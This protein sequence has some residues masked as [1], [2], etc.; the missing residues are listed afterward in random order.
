M[1]KTNLIISGVV[2]STTAFMFQNCSN[3]KY[4]YVSLEESSVLKN[5]VFDAQQLVGNIEANGGAIPSENLRVR[6]LE[7]A[8]QNMVQVCDKSKFETEKMEALEKAKA[9]PKLIAVQYSISFGAKSD[10]LALV[11][12]NRAIL[13][14]NRGVFGNQYIIPY[15]KPSA[16]QK[17]NGGNG[18][19]G[20]YAKGYYKAD[21][22]Q[23]KLD[24]VLGK[25]C[26]FNVVEIKGEGAM[27]GKY[28]DFLNAANV[29]N[30]HGAHYLLSG[31]VIDTTEDQ[32]TLYDRVENLEEPQIISLFVADFRIEQFA[33][34]YRAS[35]MKELDLARGRTGVLNTND[36]FDM[37][38]LY[39]GFNEHVW[40]LS[41]GFT[42]E[43]G[44]VFSSMV[45]VPQLTHN[46]MSGALDSTVLIPSQYTPIVLDLG[47]VGVKTTDAAWGSFFDMAAADKG[48]HR[49]AWLG[50]SFKNVK[51]DPIATTL[52]KDRRIASVQNVMMAQDVVPVS[53]DVRRIADDGFLVIPDAKGR[54]TSSKS[55]FGDNLEVGGKKFANG[56]LA[57]QALA[58]KDCQSTSIKDRYF[59]PWDKDLY[60]S[61]IKVWVDRNRN[62]VDEEGEIISLKEAG[63]VALNTCHVV[64][65]QETDSFGNGTALRSAFLFSSNA[66]IDSLLGNEDEI[67]NQLELG[68]STNGEKAQFRLAVDLVFQT[69]PDQILK[70]LE[71][72]SL[73]SR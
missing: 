58:L 10:D 35:I 13:T 57:L 69:Y 18:Y 65:Q 15:S 31:Q 3:V 8:T 71:Q 26:F 73:V 21:Y 25:K 61:K 72:L 63:V 11:A 60:Q 53:M 34:K 37:T 70:H 17:S 20:Y 48:P 55:L 4:Q 49:T 38:V 22:A 36:I 54:V 62:G 7:E 33:E 5:N 32:F 43:N 64:N 50:G 2:L 19:P 30:V 68:E 40:S 52:S 1:K 16:W 12:H 39:Q 46:L 23:A 47:E 6:S 14:E 42:G 28:M 59:G 67:L 56:F 45:G 44:K 41:H 27:N 66:Q 24:Y 51:L 9:N 29:G